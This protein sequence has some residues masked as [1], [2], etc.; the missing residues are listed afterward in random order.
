MDLD[1]PQITEHDGYAEI[2]LPSSKYKIVI[3]DLDGSV[4]ILEKKSDEDVVDL[5]REEFWKLYEML[6]LAAHR[7]HRKRFT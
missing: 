4:G 6:T 2:N 1:K 5:T 3:G 7:S